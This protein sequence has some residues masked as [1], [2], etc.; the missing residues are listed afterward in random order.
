MVTECPAA[1][2]VRVSCRAR[3]RVAAATPTTSKVLLLLRDPVTLI[4]IPARKPSVTKEPAS[5]RV[6]VS[7]LVLLKAIV[8]RGPILGKRRSLLL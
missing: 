1:S 5:V 4:F 6:M 7:G 8:V 3:V 2:V